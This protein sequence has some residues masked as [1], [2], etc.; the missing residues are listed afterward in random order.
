MTRICILGESPLLEEYGSLFLNKGCTVQGRANP[1]E[2]GALP[3]GMK[4]APKALR[5]VDAALELTNT[6]SE[7]KRQNLRELDRALP[8][9]V[10]ILTSSVTVALCEQAA[11][12]RSPNRLVGLGALPSFLEGSLVELCAH[13][14]TTERAVTAATSLIRGLGK[15]TAVVADG[16]GMVLPRLVC[17]IIN[18]AYF[19][20]QEGVAP[21]REIDTAMKLGTNYPRGPVEWAG[22]IGVRQVV[23]VLSA[24]YESFGED[25][26]R[27]APLLRKTAL[28]RIVK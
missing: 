28:A 17:M 20:M 24:L 2:T 3:R 9:G 15:E 8:P 21:A 10:P 11:W 12:V 14:Q 13:E 27:V 26:Y 16:I 22:K 7:R 25:R 19:A 1:G 23:A 4:K 6:D 18:E 5:G